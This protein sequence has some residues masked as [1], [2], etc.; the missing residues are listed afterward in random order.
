[1]RLSIIGL[2]FG[3]NFEIAAEAG[4][5]GLFL[6]ILSIAVTLVLGLLA[7]K[8]LTLNK[9]I[10]ILISVGTAICGGSAIAA[11]SPIIDAKE[12]EISVSFGIIFLLNAI[13][14]FIFPLIGYALSLAQEQFGLWSAIA[15]HDTS[16]VVGAAQTYGNTALQIATT[17]KLERAL[18]IVPLSLVSALI[19]RK[20][21]SVK[22]PY[23]ILLFIGAIALNTYSIT[24]HNIGMWIVPLAKKGMMLTLLLIGAG[25]SISSLKK[26][27]LKPLVLGVIL[28]VVIA[29]LSL[30]VILN[31]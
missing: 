16:S 22:F 11:M 24:A 9:N 19:L 3:I 10:T 31:T 1:M 13:A 5:N 4:K 27:G 28:W 18:W 25:L 15:I 26:V 7:G 21:K 20:S 14:L 29:V 6:T 2:G 30:I 23:F 17:V 12:E 8:W